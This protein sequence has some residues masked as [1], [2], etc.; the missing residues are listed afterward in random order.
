MVPQVQTL[1]GRARQRTAL[2]NPELCRVVLNRGHFLLDHFLEGDDVLRL[3]LNEQLRPRFVNG[4]RDRS[5]R[6][7]TDDDNEEGGNRRPSAFRN[8]AQIV[9]EVPLFLRRSGR[10]LFRAERT[11]RRVKILPRSL[12]KPLRDHIVSPVAG[13]VQVHADLA[14]FAVH[15]PTNLDA[16]VG[17]RSVTTPA[18]VSACGRSC[19]I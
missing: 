10:A 15:D 19:S 9:D 17:T 5:Q 2:E 3:G 6:N 8:Q 1:N 11:I 18:S 4:D 7:R 13:V 14:L 12:E 16:V